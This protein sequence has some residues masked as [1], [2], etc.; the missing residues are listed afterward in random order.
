MSGNV[1]LARK[2]WEEAIQINPF[3]PLPHERLAA[4]YGK[5]GLAK[6]AQREFEL[7]RKLHGN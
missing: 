6:D 1:S 7:T 4:L 5:L 2:A 3:D